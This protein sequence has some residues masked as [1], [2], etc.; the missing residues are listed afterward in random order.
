MSMFSDDTHVEHEC[1][2]ADQSFIL[3]NNDME[4]YF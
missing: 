3:P 4:V 2:T 1:P